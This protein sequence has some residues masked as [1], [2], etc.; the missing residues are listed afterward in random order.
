MQRH[1]TFRC[2]VVHGAGRRRGVVA[3]GRP[4]SEVKVCHLLSEHRHILADGARKGRVGPGLIN[5]LGELSDLKLAVLQL[6]A[7]VLICLLD[8]GRLLH[9]Q[10]QRRTLT[11]TSQSRL[12]LVHTSCAHRHVQPLQFAVNI[13]HGPEALGQRDEPVAHENGDE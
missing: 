3:R 10:Q 2:G 5:R 9:R 4:A 6:V 12:L 11:V 13:G 7:R 1:E 8:V